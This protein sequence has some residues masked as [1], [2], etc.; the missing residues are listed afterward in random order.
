MKSVGKHW[1]WG[2]TSY[3]NVFITGGAGFVGSVLTEMLLDD[4]YVVIVYDNLACGHREAVDPRARFILGDTGDPAA[5]R[6][7][8]RASRPDVVIHTAAYIQMAES[9]RDPGKYF[10]NN[11]ANT[12]NVLDA[13]VEHGVNRLMF[14]S[15]AGVYGF[16]C[17]LPVDE[18]HSLD[19]LNP[20]SESK[21][22]MERVIH[23]YAEI[24]GIVATV[25]RFFNAAGA[26]ARCGEDHR[27]ESHLIPLVLQVAL[28][29]RPHLELYGT[30][31][32]T[33][34]G[35]AIRDYVHV[36]DLV[37]AHLLALARPALPGVTIY[38]VGSEQGVTNLEVIEMAR[39]VTGHV[40]PVV[41]RP[42]RPGDSPAVVASSAKIRRELGW[43]PQ[44]SDLET[45]I[46]TAWAWLLSHP[47]GYERA[48]AH[49]RSTT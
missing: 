35:T 6:A 45:I 41:E 31:Y 27:P 22:Q 2:E 18:G 16:P 38:N 12:L 20:Y 43:K 30:D 5:L 24:H 46:R 3:V 21:W 32:P 48:V 13:M 23:W 11:V 7:A 42:R 14:P 25:F 4:G 15:T 37:Q 39:K 29:K 36:C 34:D 8:F 1:K 9:M 47:N 26:T 28:G 44:Y 17:N 19:P 40:I 49:V 10:R 33:R